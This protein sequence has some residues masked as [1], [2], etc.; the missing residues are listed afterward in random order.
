[1]QFIITFIWSFLLF[2][3]LNYVVSSVNAVPFD[4]GL[5]A[6]VSVI[7]AIIIFIISAIL[8]E[9]PLPDYE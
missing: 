8:P 1:M 3:T 9:E 2:T 6:I 4:L 7:A 5:G